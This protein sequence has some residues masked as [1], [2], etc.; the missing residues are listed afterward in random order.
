MKSYN[1][2]E[3]KL[4]IIFVVIWQSYNLVSE[5]SYIYLIPITLAIL[6]Y[7]LFKVEVYSN[8]ESGIKIKYWFPLG[9]NKLIS[10]DEIERCSKTSESNDI[11]IYL[12]NGERVKFSHIGIKS[13][14]L[15]NYINH[16]VSFHDRYNVGQ[17]KEN[18]KKMT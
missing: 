13:E 5:Q 12:K 11:I 14:E 9:R 3:L 7:G 17:I 10:W 18:F 1:T 16:K 15:S 2:I 6:L 4:I 8:K